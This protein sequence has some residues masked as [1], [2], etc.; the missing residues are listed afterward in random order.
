[1]LPESAEYI[2]LIESS[3]IL[4]LDYADFIACAQTML[5]SVL[6]PLCNARL[7]NRLV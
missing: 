1:M 2:T 4:E 7:D 3:L 5:P 6:A